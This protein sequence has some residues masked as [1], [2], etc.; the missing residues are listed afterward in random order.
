MQFLRSKLFDVVLALWTLVLGAAIPF[1]ILVPNQKWIRRFTRFWSS[2]VIVLLWVIVG[3]RYKVAD[4]REA[5][6]PYLYVSN[7]QSPWE[8][9]AFNS[10]FPDVA[11]VAKKELRRV[12]IF[13]WFLAKAPMILIDRTAGR[14]AMAQMIS[15]AKK[16]VDSGRSVLIYPEG[17]RLPVYARKPFQYGVAA[18]YAELNVPAVPIVH[19][20]GCFWNDEYTMKYSGEITVKF[21]P[22]IPA[23]L[24]AKEFLRCIQTQ[25]WEEKDKLAKEL[26][27]DMWMEAVG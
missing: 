13:G 14:E 24:P 15:E 11:I 10:F 5:K 2:T 8:T 16:A 6:G 27:I 21:L 23:G 18:L 4:R 3:I 26:G 7:H 20:S 25:I 22:E 1:F 17:T 9:I 12:P 19:N